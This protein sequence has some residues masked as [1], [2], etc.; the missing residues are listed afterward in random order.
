MIGNVTLGQYYPANSA[1]HRMDPRMKIILLI[2]FI[3]AV[4]CAGT[5]WAFIPVALYVFLAGYLKN[6]KSGLDYTKGLITI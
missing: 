5:L 1:V 4:F 3:V 2:L 6:S